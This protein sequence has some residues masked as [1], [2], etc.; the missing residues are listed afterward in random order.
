[1]SVNG[2]YWQVNIIFH[3]KQRLIAHYS[4]RHLVAEN[5]MAQKETVLSRAK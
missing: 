2:T 4:L 3:S 1:M 5:L